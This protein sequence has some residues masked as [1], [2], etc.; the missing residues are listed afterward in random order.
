MVERYPWDAHPD[1]TQERLQRLASAIVDVRDGVLLTHEPEKGDRSWGFGCRSLERQIEAIRNIANQDNWLSIVQDSRRFVF[2]IGQVPVRFYKGRAT[3][4]KA[5][6]LKQSYAELRQQQ[7]A[8]PFN[9]DQDWIWRFAIETD[10][11][12]TV[13][14][15]VMVEVSST[16][17][18]VRSYWE[19]PIRDRVASIAPVE[20]LQRPGKRLPPPVPGG[21]KRPRLRLV[22]GDSDEPRT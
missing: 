21:P 2:K 13:V 16:R 17:G 22:D 12:G 4:P 9:V 6:M 3:K 7:L 14:R 10:V 5:N 8:F 19:I 15:I 1:L 18:E 20:P 11:L